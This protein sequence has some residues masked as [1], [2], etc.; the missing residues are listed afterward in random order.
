MAFGGEVSLIECGAIRC[1]ACRPRVHS[2]AGALAPR[3]KASAT[4]NRI[5]GSGLMFGP[6]G[7][8][9]WRRQVSAVG[10]DGVMSYLPVLTGSTSTLR[11]PLHLHFRFCWPELSRRQHCQLVNHPC[12]AL[13]G[14]IKTWL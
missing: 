14:Q 9:V 13:Q 12:P 1:Y 6:V 8:R 11:S 10:V 2:E 5:V 7:G 3:A 4:S